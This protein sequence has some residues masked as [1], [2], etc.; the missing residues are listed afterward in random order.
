M[1]PKTLIFLP[2]PLEK[3]WRIGLANPINRVL[4]KITPAIL[5]P[6]FSVNYDVVAK[7]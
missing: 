3:I 4:E 5:K 6:Y 1:L 2:G 7:K